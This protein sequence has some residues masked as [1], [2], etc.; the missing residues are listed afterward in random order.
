VVQNTAETAAYRLMASVRASR[1][2]DAREPAT[3]PVVSACQWPFV[4]HG[5]A[6]PG[7]QNL[8]LTNDSHPP[9]LR[10]ISRSQPI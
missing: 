3:S 5:L 8:P 9:G 1:M 4:G 7:H 6:S 10:N 2:V